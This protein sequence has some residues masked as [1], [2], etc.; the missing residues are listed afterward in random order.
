[1]LAT[2]LL[3]QLT[4]VVHS[5]HYGRIST[6]QR[7]QRSLHMSDNMFGDSVRP[8][9]PQRYDNCKMLVTGV[10]G[11][12]PQERYLSNGHYVLNFAV[13]HQYYYIL[14]IGTHIIEGS[15]VLLYYSNLLPFDIF[16]VYAAGVCIYVLAIRRLNLL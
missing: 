16:I 2:L 13:S 14:F 1:M 7:L 10:V 6:A 4:A 12:V 3:L 15:V 5:F 8:L 11:T 9:T